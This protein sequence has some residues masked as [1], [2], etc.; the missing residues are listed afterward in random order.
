MFSDITDYNLKHSWMFGSDEKCDRRMINISVKLPMRRFSKHCSMIT[1][2]P[3]KKRSE[4]RGKKRQRNYRWQENRPCLS[5]LFLINSSSLP[6]LR[7]TVINV[8]ER[9][10]GAYISLC[11][12]VMYMGEI[13]G[14]GGR[15]RER[16]RDMK[17]PHFYSVTFTAVGI[18]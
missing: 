1:S 4:K 11:I 15:E 18:I 8:M 5:S 2:P 7:S 3:P 9:G 12:S 13:R 17:T 16:V 6:A 14:E 10:R